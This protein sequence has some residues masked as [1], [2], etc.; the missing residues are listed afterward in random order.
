MLCFIGGWLEVGALGVLLL[1]TVLQWAEVREGGNAFLIVAGLLGLANLL[2]SATGY[3]F[4][5]SGPRERGALGLSIATAGVAAFNLILILVIATTS[6]PNVRDELYAGV[7]WR[8]FVTELTSLPHLLFLLVGVPNLNIPV[9]RAI[10]PVFASLT[11]IAKVIMFLMAL[12]AIA[13]N[14]RDSLRAKHCMNAL[15]ANAIGSGGLIVV[16]LLFGLILAAVRTERGAAQAVFGLFSLVLLLTIA[17]LV[18]WTT[19]VTKAVKDGIDYR[20]D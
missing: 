17:A 14:A 4:L 13:R 6:Q 10:L 1:Q 5:V 12:R 2:V 9:S 3:G 19:M 16:G 8:S 7:S 11:E 18:V 15:I 20:R